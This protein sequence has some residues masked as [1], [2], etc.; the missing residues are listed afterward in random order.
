MTEANV[1]DELVVRLTLDGKEYDKTDKLVEQKTKQTTK[2]QEEAS[3]KEKQRDA[4]SKKRQQEQQKRLKEFAGTVKA[5]GGAMAALAGIG[6]GMSLVGL[7]AGLTASESAMK[8]QSTATGMS[9]RQ[10][11]AWRTSMQRLSGDAEGG[12]AAVAALA[13]EQQT[14][15]M[16]GPMP[17]IAALASAGIGVREGESVESI[18]SRAQERYR[19]MPPAQ[20]Q[21]MENMLALQ[22]VDPNIIQAI[23]S[24]Q[25]IADVY[26]KSFGESANMDEKGVDAFN[27][28]LA[29]LKNQLRD[30]ATVLMQVLT[31]AIQTLAPYI[32]DAA[33]WVAAF[34]ND[35]QAS[36]GGIKGFVD[37]LSSRSS[38]IGAALD[39]LG[40]V[41]DVVTFGLKEIA[42]VIGKAYDWINSK[43]GGLL[44]LPQAGNGSALDKLGA[45]IKDIWKDTVA[46]ARN[47]GPAPYARMEG[48]A[49]TGG[50][51]NGVHL[52]QSAANRIAAGALGPNGGKSGDAMQWMQTLIANGAT[53][54]QAAAITANAQAESGLGKNM[55]QIGGDRQ[56]AGFLQ[57]RGARKAAYAQMFGHGPESGTMQEMIQFLATDP[58]EK[59]SVQAAFANGGSAADLGRAFSEKFERHGNVAEDAA[60][61]N[62]AQRYYDQFQQTGN[63]AQPIAGGPTGPQI[64][65]NGPVT[66]QANNPQEF[67]TGVQRVSGVNNYNSATR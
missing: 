35:M 50:S 26:G 56:A 20:Q 64:A 36:G 52:T 53:P 42:L 14:A 47:E 43:L 4:E 7:L 23:K 13:R 21:H 58:E 44:G 1:V 28:A 38:K 31:P 39:F 29:T 10:I 30:T 32:S 37:T 40:Q 66:V 48:M 51:P 22:N 6:A 55:V 45:M 65:I 8:R 33:K 15:R 9:V 67:M 34:S 3:R 18:L 2:T 54:A 11:N 17:T 46:T 16:G 59:R 57:W 41:L 49:P 63:G 19:A 61:G 24:K 62:L 60:R 12:A 5:F 27:D 25:S